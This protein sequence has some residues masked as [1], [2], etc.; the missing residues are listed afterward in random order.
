M[1]GACAFQ[2][3]LHG[4]SLARDVNTPW[5]KNVLKIIFLMFLYHVVKFKML[6]LCVLREPCY[7]S[8]RWAFCPVNDCR[9]ELT[10]LK[11]S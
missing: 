4:K 10:H 8:V 6:F 3:C 7:S 9:G 5:N 2:H 1:E 11:R